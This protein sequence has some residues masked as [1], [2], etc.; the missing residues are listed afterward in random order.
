MPQLSV[1]IPVKNGMPYLK[2][3]ITSTL[4]AMPSDSELLVLDDGSTDGTA[5]YLAAVRDRRLKVFRNDES[6]GV[7]SAATTLLGHATGDHVA[8]IDGDDICLPWRFSTQRRALAGADVVFSGALMINAQ[9]KPFRPRLERGISPEAMPLHL[10]LTNVLMNPTMY[11][12]RTALESLGGYQATPA[13]DYDLWLRAAS[14]GTRMRRMAALPTI[15]YRRHETQLS[16]TRKWAKGDGDEVLAGSFRI[17]ASA[18][19]GF[20]GSASTILYN[21]PAAGKAYPEDPDIADFAARM[22][23]AAARLSDK[24]RRGVETRLKTTYRV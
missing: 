6:A 18:Q 21:R 3:T 24:D 22:L 13:E 2:S 19:L 20:E 10:L 11:A 5:S 4:R 14:S 8:R 17:L 15:A 9:G 1:L 23:A 16:Q 12:S 7:A